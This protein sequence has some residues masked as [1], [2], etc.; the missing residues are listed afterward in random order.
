MGARYF[1]LMYLK[2]LFLIYFFYSFFCFYRTLYI[3]LIFYD[4][5]TVV[6]RFYSNRAPIYI[7]IVQQGADMST[8]TSS[9]FLSFSG[10]QYPHMHKPRSGVT[11]SN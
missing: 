10:G 1:V 6:Q 7:Y 11:E 4:N 8:I 9:H 2:G 3:N 5:V